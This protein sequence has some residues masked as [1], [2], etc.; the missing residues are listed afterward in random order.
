MKAISVEEYGDHDVLQLR[1]VPDPPVG[2][3]TVRIRVKAAGVNPVDSYM[4]LGSMHS[5]YPQH[6]PLIPGW[7][8]AGVVDRVGAA[9]TRF[10]P[11]DEV[12]A[13]ARKDSVQHG[14]YAELVS[15]ADTVVGRK[16][17]ALSFAQAGG[18]PLAGLTA[19][20]AARTLDVGPGDV[21]LVHA[22]AGGVGHFGVQIARA[23]G[24]ARVIGTASVGNHEFLRSLGA[25]PIEY[26][27]D[28]PSRLAELVGGDGRVDVALDFF[29]G[30]ALKQSPFL[31]RNAARHASIVDPAV[32]EQGGQYVYV[33]PNADDLNAL[34]DL[35]DRGRLW[36]EVFR[37]L[38]LA[39]AA[40]AQ[41]LVEER[42]TR[43]KVVLIP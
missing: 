18:I 42:H 25:E 28:L 34:A 12:M 10:A 16:P 23:M 9:V 1:E 5:S 3:D 27:P 20:Q 14:T 43:G 35:A 13:Y 19:W 33:R 8:V 41:R 29:G 31:V 39:S 36:T 15:V 6:L 7:D 37:E 32:K 26:G 38:P 30:D 2:S 24:A 17:K 22:A 40:E 21:V 11:G 4:R